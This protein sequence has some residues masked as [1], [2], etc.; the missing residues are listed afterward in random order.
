MKKSIALL[1]TVLLCLSLSLTAC[2]KMSDLS[3][4]SAADSIPNN[5]LVQ[6]WVPPSMWTPPSITILPSLTITLLPSLTISPLLFPVTIPDTAL[7]T[8]LHNI[9]GKLL[10]SDLLKADLASLSGTLDL[11]GLGIADATGIEYCT[12]ISTLI[13]AENQLSDMPDNLSNMT[14]LNNLILRDNEFTTLPD[15]VTAVSGLT[16]L[17]MSY[18][19]MESL[20]DSLCSMPN[21][22]SLNV[23]NNRLY[24][25]PSNIGSTKIQYLFAGGNR[26]SG[27]PT[28]IGTSTSLDY[29]DMRCNRLT[30]LPSNLSERTFEE[31]LLDFNFMD[32]STGSGT[33]KEINQIVATVQKLFER[34][35]LP[36]QNLQAEPGT[37]Q[38]T[39]KWDAAEGYEGSTY[40]IEVVGYYLYQMNGS[41]MVSIDTLGAEETTYTH[42][43]LSL[44]TEY[45]YR[46]GVEYK[47]MEPYFTANTRY[48]NDDLTVK[49]LA[50][51]EP[52]ATPSAT[53]SSSTSTASETATTD[54]TAETADVTAQPG[55]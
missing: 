17:N 40:T 23:S 12:N 24:S 37:E 5:G 31:I 47:V 8:A 25:L 1:I 35:L 14:S 3:S 2:L 51:A 7:N 18:N 16:S 28:S 49:T 38:I 19:S 39:L 26:I 6:L 42:T 46:I 41:T 11:T 30:T 20:P 29:L 43:G 22:L 36:I 4:T 34:Q 9:C 54:I 15:S 44:S 52:S 32:V 33:R 45:T 27:L 53:P 13:L 50:Q 48:Y 55:E 21:L 10:S